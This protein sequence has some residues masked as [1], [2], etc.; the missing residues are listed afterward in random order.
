[1]WWRKKTEARSDIASRLR[2]NDRI[3]L[4]IDGKTYLSRVEDIQ[5]GDLHVAAPAECGAMK[6]IRSDIVVKLS[7]GMKVRRFSGVIKGARNDRITL[8]VITDLKC[9]GTAQRREH[10]RIPE[11]IP[12]RFRFDDNRRH[13]FCWFEGVTQDIS[14]GGLQVTTDR[15]GIDSILRGDLLDLELYLPDQPLV[16]ATGRVARTPSHDSLFRYTIQ[17]GVQF[18]RISAGDRSRIV[19]HVLRKQADMLAS[20][21]DLVHCCQ[22]ISV[23]YYCIGE[24]ISAGH[25]MA[26]ATDMSVSGLKMTLGMT[27]AVAVGI[28]LLL[29]IELPGITIPVQGE[30]LWLED[31]KSGSSGIQAGI[32]FTDISTKAQLEIDRFLEDQDRNDASGESRAA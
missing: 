24:G 14:G 32:R 13:V 1:M 18:A 3:Q 2:V 22:P 11:R 19:R 20:R 7:E 25:R 16:K 17:F 12:V 26:H 6:A 31:G 8:L 27:D 30:V 10:V 4:E 23:Q 29:R 21:R 9:L 5:G 15:S 28:S